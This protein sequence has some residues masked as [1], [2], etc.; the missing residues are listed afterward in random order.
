M[1]VYGAD[2]VWRQ[3]NREGNLFHRRVRDRC[4]LDVRP[5]R[6]SLSRCLAWLKFT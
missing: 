5:Q 6:V 1:Q 4:H 2:K 3:L